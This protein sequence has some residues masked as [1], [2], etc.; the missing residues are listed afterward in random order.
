MMIRQLKELT[1]IGHA[2]ACIGQSCSARV[3]K[4]ALQNP[5]AYLR[6]RLATATAIA[7]LA[8]EYSLNVRERIS[9]VKAR[10]NVNVNATAKQQPKRGKMAHAMTEPAAGPSTQMRV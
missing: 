6:E 3:I 9:S 7:R 1:C 8:L 4:N 5:G 2:L 10:V